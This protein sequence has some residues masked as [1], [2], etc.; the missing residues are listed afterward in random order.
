MKAFA[1]AAITAVVL[2]AAT[3]SPTLAGNA[4]QDV[5]FK[6]GTSCLPNSVRCRKEYRPQHP[7]CWTVAVRDHSGTIRK[8][9]V[10]KYS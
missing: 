8:R 6:S 5:Q 4:R 1:I 9:R 7:R 2:A 10:C 3:A